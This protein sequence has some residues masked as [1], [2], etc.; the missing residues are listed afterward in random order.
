MKFSI[1]LSY[2]N[3][4]LSL[5]YLSKYLKNNS[6][7]ILNTLKSVNVMFNA[8]YIK[9]VNNKN[10]VNFFLLL[11][12][13]FELETLKKIYLSVRRNKKIKFCYDINYT[14]KYYSIQLVAIAIKA[15]GVGKPCFLQVNLTFTQFLLSFLQISKVQTIFLDTTSQSQAA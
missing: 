10:L 6:L 3:F 15:I 14:C 8:V 7:L 4:F 11:V 1:L 2:L 5:N 12:F 9:L 13:S